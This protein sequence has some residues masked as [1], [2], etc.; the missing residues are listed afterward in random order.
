MKT[1]SPPLET[2][3]KIINWYFRQLVIKSSQV[4]TTDLGFY[5]WKRDSDKESTTFDQ[6]LQG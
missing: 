2:G 1:L 5:I 3:L 6:K 4:I